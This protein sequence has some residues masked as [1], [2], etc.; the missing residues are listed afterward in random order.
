MASAPSFFDTDAT[1]EYV[2]TPYG[3]L[4]ASGEWYH[5]T[6]EGLRDYAGD[7]FDHVPLDTLLHWA[8]VWIRSARALT[9]WALPGFLWIVPSLP[10][11]ACALGLYIGWK[12]FSPA[13]LNL[14]AV[15]FIGSME[16]VVL[17]GLYYVFT[18]SILASTG[19]HV[20]TVVGLAGFAL[21]RF[22]ALQWATQ[23]LLRPIWRALYPLPIADQVLRGFI[24]RVALKHRLELAQLDTMTR[25]IIANWSTRTEDDDNA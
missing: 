2:D 23:P 22:G 12:T 8:D 21:L 20:A 6:E 15:R 3:I 4:T 10:A 14:W 17:Q 9:L 11:A 24:I 7:V 25:D 1:P 19:A 13:V 18:L 5:V 16:N